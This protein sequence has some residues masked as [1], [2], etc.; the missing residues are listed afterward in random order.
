MQTIAVI[1]QKGGSGK[2]TIALGLA[3][4]AVAAGKQ[5][6]VIDLD[7]QA[8][9]AN[10]GD[11][12]E[13]E[14]APVVVSCQAARLRHVLEA[15]RAQ[16]VELALIDTPPK[17]SDAAIV[18]AKAGDRVLIPIQPHLFD[19]ETLDS[20]R[21]ILAL[22]GQPP[23]AVV[24]NRAPIQGRRHTDA[25]TGLEGMGYQVAPIVLY[26][27]AAHG[28]AANLG[29]TA[30]EYDPHGKAAEEMQKLYSYMAIS[31]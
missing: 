20:V 25:Q 21:E 18:A 29:K 7:P 31:L 30:R 10:W 9:A 15:A 2:T 11:R 1:S 13:Q 23:T 26:Q 3:V 12:R 14:D 22:A 16:G 24:I 5:V 19:I 4:E 8:S 28:D 27:R 6:A 17:S